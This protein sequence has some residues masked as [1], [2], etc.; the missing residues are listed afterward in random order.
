MTNNQRLVA[1]IAQL[2]KENMELVND[3]ALFREH[4]QQRFQWWTK[5]L[6]EGSNPNLA[7]VI[8]SDAKWLQRFKYWVW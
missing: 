1:R 7:W 5:L 4:F 8:E 2:E 3:R 6:K